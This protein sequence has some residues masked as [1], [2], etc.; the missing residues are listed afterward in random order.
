MPSG[1]DEMT[2]RAYADYSGGTDEERARRTLLRETM[3]KQG[4]KVI[5]DEWWHFDYKDWK[6]YPII[7]VRFE[8]L[9]Q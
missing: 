2:D 5:S 6:L 1:Y 4:F 9:G 3:E 7:N 8:D